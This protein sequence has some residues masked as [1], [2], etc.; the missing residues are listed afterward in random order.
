MSQSREQRLP[1]RGRQGRS[2]GRIWPLATV[3]LLAGLLCGCGYSFGS[4]L[5]DRGIRTVFV[6]AVGND[7]YR[8][9]LE[10]ELSTAVSE[11]LPVLSDLLP[12]SETTADAI[13]ELSFRQA[14]ERTLVT[15]GRTDPVREGA[16]EANLHM[17][18]VERQTGRLLLERNI[19]DRAEFH[20]PI[21]QNLETARAQ[22]I[23]DMTR[24]IIL[25][26]ETGF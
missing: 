3:W 26:L 23:A 16:L 1:R 13:L 21:G 11:A 15:G 10:V 20:A 6:Q 22:L 8:Q 24:K 14:R 4:G 5:R 2:L 25:A 19:A 7:T 9:R 17:R 12:G 18:L